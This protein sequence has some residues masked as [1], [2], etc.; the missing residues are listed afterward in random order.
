[1]VLLTPSAL[2]IWN[3]SGILIVYAFVGFYSSSPVLDLISLR[4]SLNV[5]R[6]TLEWIFLSIQDLTPHDCSLYLL[7]VGYPS[8]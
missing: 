7:S 6:S 3:H 5:Y 8:L 2:F 1:M 4:Q